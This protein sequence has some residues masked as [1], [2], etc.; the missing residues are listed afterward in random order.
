MVN[1]G[2]GFVAGV[3]VG[4][5]LGVIWCGKMA[6]KAIEEIRKEWLQ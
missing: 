1:I 5:L 4:A 3:Y 6:D 2:L